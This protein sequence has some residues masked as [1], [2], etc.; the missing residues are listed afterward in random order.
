[1]KQHRI[2]F[3]I[4]V[5]FFAIISNVAIA[6]NEQNSQNPQQQNN[7]T[8]EQ[9]IEQDIPNNQLNLDSLQNLPQEDFG[10]FA[11]FVLLLHLR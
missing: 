3:D 5:F 10:S 11:H 4:V 2:L 6:Q 9:I 7:L 1:M 8:L